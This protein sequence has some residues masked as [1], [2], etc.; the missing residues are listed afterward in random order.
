[1]HNT[2]AVNIGHPLASC[3]RMI[4]IKMLQITAPR[5]EPRPTHLQGLAWFKLHQIIIA[6]DPRASPPYNGPLRL[7]VTHPALI[8]YDFLIACQSIDRI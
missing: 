6:H 1:M 4:G 2:G 7:G 5:A 3:S 8:S